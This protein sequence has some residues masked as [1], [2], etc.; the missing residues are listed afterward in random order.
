MPMI[1]PSSDLRN[2]YNDI[3]EFVNTTN[4]PVFITKNG[5][6][7][8][9]VMSID[10]YESLVREARIDAVIAA[11]EAEMEAGAEP[12]DA[13]EVLEELRRKHFG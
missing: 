10:A 8:V 3:S 13:K 11:A 5:Y 1:R 2:K 9:V 4:E 12:R 6:G 7:D